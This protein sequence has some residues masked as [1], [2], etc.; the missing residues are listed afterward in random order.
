MQAPSKCLL[1]RQRQGNKLLNRGIDEEM[2]ESMN[3]EIVTCTSELSS[4]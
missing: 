3:E 4:V 1:L 2:D